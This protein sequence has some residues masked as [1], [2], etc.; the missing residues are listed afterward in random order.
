[1]IGAFSVISGFCASLAS[2]VVT[3]FIVGVGMSGALAVTVALVNEFAPLRLRATSVTVVFSGTTIGP[4]FRVSSPLFCSLTAA[5]GVCFSSAAGCRS[6][7]RRF[8]GSR[9]RNRPSICACEPSATPSS[10]VYCDDSSRRF[11]YHPTPSSYW[12][13]SPRP[14]T[15]A[16]RPRF[17]LG[18]SPCSRGRM[19]D[20][21]R[22]RHTRPAFRFDPTC[23]RH[24]G[25]DR[26]DRD[27]QHKLRCAEPRRCRATRYGR[28]SGRL[29]T[30]AIGRRRRA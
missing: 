17:S 14:P 4:A 22:I 26:G 27:L 5:G 15:C 6:S 29:R 16:S 19:M 21:R 8:C 25:I 24:G 12:P 18:S 3:R 20:H 11:G 7:S 13:S 23:R 9:C 30:L 28:R 2:L 10:A 1:M